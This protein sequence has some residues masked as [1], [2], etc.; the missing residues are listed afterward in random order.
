[1]F[2]PVFIFCLISISIFTSCRKPAPSQKIVFTEVPP[3]LE[4]GNEKFSPDDFQDSYDKNKFASDS[5]R[6]LTPAEY[7]NLYS[8]LKI[9]VLQAKQEGRD[10]TSDY[11]EE[12]ASYKD[13]LAKNFVV[14]KTIV[15]KLATEAYSRLKQEVRASHILI[16]VPEDAAPADTLEAYRAALALRGRLE[17]GSD[18]GDIAARFSK[19][20]KG[21]TNTSGGHIIRARRTA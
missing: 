8:D 21:M 7:I 9:K 12:I 1:M 20:P 16:A 14:D 19:A 10:T 4:I 3:L 15:D 17:E 11:R 18:F 5:S 6:S 13:Q 2:K